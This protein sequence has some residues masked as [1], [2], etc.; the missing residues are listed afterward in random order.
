MATS[1][2]PKDCTWSWLQRLL[3]ALVLCTAAVSDGEALAQQAGQRV[4]VDSR[5]D[6]DLYLAGA[7]VEVRAEVG[8]DV[9]A[10]A[11]AVTTTAEI[12]Q[13]LVAAGGTVEV[14][15][16]VG[17]DVRLVGGELTLAGDVGDAAVLAG[18]AVRVS[19]G[20]QVGG[21]ALIA[22]GRVFLDGDVAGELRVAAGTVRIGGSVAGN[23]TIDA[24]D[25]F[26]LGPGARFGGDLVYTSP[27]PVVLPQ[28][29]TVAGRVVHRPLERPRP[30]VPA[31]AAV[32]GVLWLLGLALAAVVLLI[33]FPRLTVGAAR[34]VATSAGRALLT[35]AV[36]LFVIPFATLVALLTGIGAPLA[37]AV[38]GI[39][40]VALLAGWLVAAGFVA[41]VA[42]RALLRREP[43]L[44]ARAGLTAVAA[45]VLALFGAIPV[46]GWLVSL[47]AFLLG[48]GA[49]LLALGRTL[50]SGPP[51]AATE[52]ARTH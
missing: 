30:G 13:D 24:R 37:L 45:V 46:L 43:G 25:R 18:G 23:A 26:E 49:L 3:L 14:R 7:T 12:T 34:L 51:Q 47:A 35:G 4:V 9:I 27:E 8:G 50:R 15:G 28:G 17:D 31:G 48:T 21:Q 40:L 19:R 39:W 29:V 16:R 1:G 52:G 38:L 10:G 20:V 42:A 2:G 32:F 6:R 44:G 11:G 33:A 41:D 5:V 36:A 22:A